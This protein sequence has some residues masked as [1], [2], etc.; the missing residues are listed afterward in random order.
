MSD[1][2][3][4]V[5]VAGVQF[6]VVR[7]PLGGPPS[8]RTLVLLHDSLGCITTWRDFPEELGKAVGCDVLVYDRQGYGRS[9]PFGPEPRDARYMHR[10]A[11]VLN[12][13]LEAEGITQAVLF[14]H[15]D[16]G[17]IALLAA[18]KYPQ[19]IAAMITEGA[20]VFVEEVTLNGIRAAERQYATTGLRQRLMKHHG[21]RTDALFHAW[22]RTWQAPFFRDWNITQEISAIH[23]PLLVLQGVDDEYGTEAQVDAIVSAVG[24]RALKYMI[25][26]AAHTPHKEA[27]AITM[28]L[29]AQFLR[30][31]AGG[32]A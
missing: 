2:I 14:G 9:D 31:G 6:A 29:A 28:E 22:A 12:A 26:G 20:H 32:R 1:P 18:A 27:P 11:D 13:L 17:T 15:S 21:D 7:C 16:G 19:R 10:E 4:T 8:A 24:D 25:P 3:R 23:C 5:E 30:D